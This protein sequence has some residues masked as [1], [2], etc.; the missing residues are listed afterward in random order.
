[1]DSFRLCWQVRPGG[2]TEC[3]APISQDAA[4]FRLRD[5]RVA[6]PAIRSWIMEEASEDRPPPSWG[7]GE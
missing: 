4:Q 7:I 6:F 5:Q 2:R 1:M 3:T